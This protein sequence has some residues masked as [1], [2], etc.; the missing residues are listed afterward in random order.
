[1]ATHAIGTFYEGFLAVG[2]VPDA[3][4]AAIQS[5]IVA[6]GYKTLKADDV[7]Q[8]ALSRTAPSC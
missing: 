4:D 1:M 8:A 3:T 2:S 5:N 6:V 7:L